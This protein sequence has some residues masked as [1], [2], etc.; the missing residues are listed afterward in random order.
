MRSLILALGFAGSVLAAAAQ[1][2]R[3]R[4]AFIG[5]VY[6]TTGDGII[7]MD[8]D[9]LLFVAE[10]EGMVAVPLTGVGA[11]VMSIAWAPAGP[12]RLAF[13]AH[14]TDTDGD[15][16]IDR[17]DRASIFVAEFNCP[18]GQLADCI[19]ETNRLTGDDTDDRCPTWS[20]DGMQIAFAS[21]GGASA[22]VEIIDAGCATGAA[23]GC[24]ASRQ[25]LAH[26]AAVYLD[27]AWSPDR[28]YIAY[29]A[30]QDVRGDGVFNR[31][32]DSGALRIVKVDTGAVIELAPADG[33][34]GAPAWSPDGRYLAYYA[35]ADTDGDGH[36][37]AL[38]DHAGIFVVDIDR[39]GAPPYRVTD[40]AVHATDPAWSPAARLLS[41]GELA[42]AYSALTDT[43]GDGWLDAYSDSANIFAAPFK[44]GKWGAPYAL[45]TPSTLDYAPTWSPDGRSVAYVSIR[46]GAGGGTGSVVNRPGI[47]FA[48]DADAACAPGC[49]AWQVS[50]DQVD[51][52][53]PAWAPR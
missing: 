10:A 13:H 8:D 15:R 50:P 17:D 4:L 40:P 36:A 47:I 53:A 19:F 35:I 49:A 9:G 16:R 46:A 43:D 21:R 25:A 34:K 38:Y 31:L 51:A 11:D 23:D 44:D 52:F 45:T 18:A 32:E 14:Y 48:V 28:R 42:L 33:P 27:L 20:P 5:R 6:D 41:A 2:D 26:G 30:M 24:T 37:D 22:A 39:P 1:A 29:L 3:P 7:D 12:R